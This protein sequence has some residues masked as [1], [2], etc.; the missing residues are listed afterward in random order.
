[1]PEPCLEKYQNATGAGKHLAGSEIAVSGAQLRR[2][3]VLVAGNRKAVAKAFLKVRNDQ[4]T[5]DKCGSSL[6]A[7]LTCAQ[8]VENFM[9][10]KAMIFKS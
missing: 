3:A 4:Y 5:P 10:G 8:N 9:K 1:M 2:C 6:Q 7:L